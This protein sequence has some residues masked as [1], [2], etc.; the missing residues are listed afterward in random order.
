MRL[1]PTTYTFVLAAAFVT[2]LT[3]A[4][5]GLEVMIQLYLWLG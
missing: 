5:F 1:D 2:A 3:A 4:L